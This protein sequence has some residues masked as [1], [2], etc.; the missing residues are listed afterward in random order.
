MGLPQTSFSQFLLEIL[1]LAPVFHRVVIIS[2]N[3][4]CSV[5]Y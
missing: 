2:H 3:T 5:K 4:G 1:G